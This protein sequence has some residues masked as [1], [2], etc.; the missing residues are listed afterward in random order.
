MRVGRSALD[1]EAIRLIEEHNPEVEFDWTRILKGGV[2][3]KAAPPPGRERFERGGRRRPDAPPPPPM[4]AP[5][6]VPPPVAS[7]ETAEEAEVFPEIESAPLETI[8]VA[9]A[10]EPAVIEAIE[11]VLMVREQLDEA[12]AAEAREDAPPT[13]AHA[14]LGAE[15]VLRLRARYAEVRARISERVPEPARQD[16]LKA[17][18]DRLNPDTWVTAA[19]VS[20]GL[21]EYETVFEALRTA[22]GGQGRGRRHKGRPEGGQPD[23]AGGSPENQG[24]EDS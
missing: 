19:E 12:P 17:Q 10:F 18:A 11:Q 7:I 4:P 9:S 14:K 20:A 13:A 16:E 2:E 24:T 3:V 23:P 6:A 22:V 15:G 1:E 5:Q 21:E 8:A